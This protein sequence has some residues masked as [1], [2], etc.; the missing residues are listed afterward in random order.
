MIRNFSKN[1]EFE[2][3]GLVFETD[4]TLKFDLT[5]LNL[6]KNDLFE[7]KKQLC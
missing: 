2:I 5:W 7:F 3:P 1:V 4:L 6:V